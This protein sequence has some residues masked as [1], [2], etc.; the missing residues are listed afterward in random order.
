MKIQDL[1]LWAY[2]DTGSGRNFISSE[3]A[4]KLKLSPKRHET[5]QM[6]TLNGTKRQSMP[7]LSITMV[8][9]DGRT[10][11]KIEVTGSKMP[12]FATVKRPNTSELNMGMLET[13]GSM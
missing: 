13:R 11:E 3:A 12:E 6:V 7:V 9:L 8:S 5:C 2:L 1:T 4:K 10:R